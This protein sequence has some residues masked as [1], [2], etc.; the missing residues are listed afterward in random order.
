MQY[1]PLTVRGGF[2]GNRAQ[3]VAGAGGVEVFLRLGV[4]VGADYRRDEDYMIAGGY[5]RF[6]TRLLCIATIYN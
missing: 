3:F 6:E 5:L 2:S 1:Y 4:N